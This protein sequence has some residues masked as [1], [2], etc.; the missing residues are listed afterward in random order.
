[1]IMMLLWDLEGVLIDV[2]CAFLEG[3][4]EEEVY[5]HCPEGLEGANNAENCLRLT[6][7]I[8][9]LVQS[10]RQWWKKF[11]KILREIGFEGGHADPCLFTRKND[12]GI[13]FIALYVD[14]CLCIGNEAAIK[15]MVH[16]L[17]NRDLK[18][19]VDE[20]LRDYLSCEIHFSRDRKSVVLHQQHII[21]SIANEFGGEVQ[22]LQTYRTPGTPGVGMIRDPDGVTVT[23]AEQ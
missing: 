16:S 5:M 4:L 23:E 17:R 21:N 10:A 22:N 7:S 1:M 8:Y 15:D 19:T 3:E 6:K 2:E 20:K 13:I 11:V 14:D 18:L 9:G 12:K